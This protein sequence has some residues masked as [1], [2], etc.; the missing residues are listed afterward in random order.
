MES[1]SSKGSLHVSGMADSN[2]I[3]Y[4]LRLF[5]INQE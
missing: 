1:T 3:R 4:L 5:H 2:A